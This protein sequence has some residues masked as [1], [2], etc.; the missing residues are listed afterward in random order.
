MP[1][2]D[3]FYVS[4]SGRLLQETD[5]AFEKNAGELANR[6]RSEF[7]SVLT[8]IALDDDG[9]VKMRTNRGSFYATSLGVISGG[10]LTLLKELPTSRGLEEFGH[11]FDFIANAKGSFRS[12]SFRVSVFFRF[13]PDDGQRLIGGKGLQNALRMIAGNKAPSEVSSYRFLSTFDNS[14]FS[15]SIELESSE[16]DVQLRYSRTSKE[17]AFDSYKAFLGAAGVA[18]LVEDLK[19]FADELL[20]AQPTLALG[21][22]PFVGRS[23]K[24]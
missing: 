18:A 10:W 8:D 14:G 22:I 16:T 9:D 24:K 6:L 3:D 2:F 11:L 12:K 1:T 19:P 15:D 17:S 4:V 20:A 5:F 7:G 23:P 13:T 21:R